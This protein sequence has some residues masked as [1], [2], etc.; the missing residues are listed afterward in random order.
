MNIPRSLRGPQSLAIYILLSQ[1]SFSQPVLQPTASQFLPCRSALELI[2]LDNRKVWFVS[3]LKL[4]R[5]CTLV[6]R[7]I[8]FRLRAQVFESQLGRNCWMDKILLVDNRQQARNCCSGLLMFTLQSKVNLPMVYIFKPR[9]LTSH[10]ILLKLSLSI[11]RKGPNQVDMKGLNIKLDLKSYLIQFFDRNA[12][13]DVHTC[14]KWLL[15]MRIGQYLI[16]FITNGTAI[17]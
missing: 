3:Y 6:V 8:G 1:N 10:R 16:V 14:T 13:S 15:L 17:K 11:S 12:I 5:V 9:R 2:Y 4:Q 7:C